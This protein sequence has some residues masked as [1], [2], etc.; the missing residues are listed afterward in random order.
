MFSDHWYR[1]HQLRPALKPHVSLTKHSYAGAPT[2]MLIDSLNGTQHRLGAAAY[3]LV[4]RMDGER[5]V[6]TL[7]D[8][9]MVELDAVAPTQGDF[10]VYNNPNDPNR[11]LE[12]IP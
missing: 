11:R 8:A 5:T 6:Q 10:I 7:W 9:S 4:A 12:L 1:V 3:Y 2:W